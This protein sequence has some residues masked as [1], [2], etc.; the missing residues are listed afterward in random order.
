MGMRHMAG[1]LG[2]VEILALVEPRENIRLAACSLAGDLPIFCTDDLGEALARDSY[3]LAILSA[4]AEGRLEQLERVLSV[5][6]P[7][8]LAEKPLEQS[9]V[10][11]RA[12]I[13]MAEESGAAVWSNHYRRNLQ[14]F[15]PWLSSPEPL[16][17][18]VTSGAMG[19][20]CNGIHWIDFAMHLTGQAEGRLLFG[21]IDSEVILSGRGP[22]F[23]DCGGRGIFGF[24]DGSRLFLSSTARSS[25]PTVLSILGANRHWLIDQ[26]TDRAILHERSREFV[27]P[28]YLYGKDYL[29]RDGSGLEFVDLASETRLF[30]Q[31]LKRGEAPA[32]P[33]LRTLSQAYEL[34]FD[35]LE[36]GGGKTFCFT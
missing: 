33:R 1:L 22:Q 19:L 9:R 2:E 18:S 14:G 11:V 30:V 31:A 17:I 25:A 4:T 35:L 15:S 10:R 28:A 36:M 5:G 3:D 34:L 32:H 24:P 26:H 13:Q 21:E 6:I 27:S 16:V 8:V 23:S 7:S 29:T 12:M 20:A